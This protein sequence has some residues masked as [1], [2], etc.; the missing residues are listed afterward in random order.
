MNTY[1]GVDPE[2]LTPLERTHFLALDRFVEHESLRATEQLVRQRLGEP[3]GSVAMPPIGSWQVGAADLASLNS[4]PDAQAGADGLALPSSGSS[5]SPA[6]LRGVEPRSAAPSLLGHANSYLPRAEN[7]A[8]PGR[9][10]PSLVKTINTIGREARVHRTPHVDAEDVRPYPGSVPAA[11]SLSRLLSAADIDDSTGVGNVTVVERHLSFSADGAELAAS[12]DRPIT[13]DDLDNAVSSSD[14]PSRARRLGPVRSRR[15]RGRASRGSRGSGSRALRSRSLSRSLSRPS[16]LARAQS[17]HAGQASLSRASVVRSN[18][19]SLRK[20]MAAARKTPT[21]AQSSMRLQPSPALLEQGETV[22]ATSALAMT[23]SSPVCDA[24]H[25]A[26][27]SRLSPLPSGSRMREAHRES[28]LPPLP[29]PLQPLLTPQLAP[30]PTPNPARA[31]SSNDDDDDDSVPAGFFPLSFFDDATFDELNEKLSLPNYAVSGLSK[32]FDVDGSWSWKP[33]LV[34]GYNADKALYQIEWLSNHSLKWVSRLNL[35]FDGE[36]MSLFGARLQ[37]ALVARRE[38]EAMLRYNVRI[39]LMPTDG[40]PELDDAAYASIV[41]RVGRDFPHAATLT[42]R[43]RAVAAAAVTAELVARARAGASDTGA[44]PSAAFEPTVAGTLFTD[45]FEEAVRYHYKRTINQMEF[46]ATLPYRAINPAEPLPAPTPPVAIPQLGTLVLPHHDFAGHFASLASAHFLARPNLAAA[47]RASWSFLASV[48]D[49]PLLLS[50]LLKPKSRKP[51]KAVALASLT[52]FLN[53]QTFYMRNTVRDVRYITIQSLNNALD[54][55]LS[56]HANAAPYDVVEP[57]ALVRLVNLMLRDALAIVLASSIDDYTATFVEYI[58]ELNRMHAAC[59]EALVA[60]AYADADYEYEYDEEESDPDESTHPVASSSASLAPADSAPSLAG[61]ADAAADGASASSGKS[62]KKRTKEEDLSALV[63]SYAENF[64]TGNASPAPDAAL[65]PAST[66]ASRR[67]SAVS[68]KSDV[69]EDAP[70]FAA[71]ASKTLPP[72]PS[73]TTALAPPKVKKR[74]ARTLTR[75]VVAASEPG[76][77]PPAPMFQLFGVPGKYL[78]R[79]TPLFTVTL[80]VSPDSDGLLVYSPSV[81][82]VREV[83]HHLVDE[84]V[85]AIQDLPTVQ[86]DEFRPFEVPPLLAPDHESSP[87]MVQ[88]RAALDKALDWSGAYMRGY[89]S[90]LERFHVLLAQT[91]TEYVASFTAREPKPKPADYAD[92]VRKVESLIV[93]IRSLIDERVVMGMFEVRVVEVKAELERAAHRLRRALLKALRVDTQEYCQALD[94]R[95]AAINVKL[96]TQPETPEEL[97]MLKKFI[98]SLPKEKRKLGKRAAELSARFALLE[99][100]GYEISDAIASAHYHI[101]SWPR[102]LDTTMVETERLMGLVRI[103]MTREIKEKLSNLEA[104][105]IDA[106]IAIK[107]FD[108]ADNLDDAE[109]LGEQA[110]AL[111]TTLRDLVKEHALYNKHERLFEFEPSP[112]PVLSEALAEFKP[113]YT[114]WSNAAAWF[115]KQG[116]WLGQTFVTLSASAMEKF[117]LKTYKTN[118]KVLRQLR[119]QHIA[120]ATAATALKEAI[121]TFRAHMPIIKKLRH[122]GIRRRHWAQLNEKTGLNISPQ[123]DWNLYYFVEQHLENHIEEVTKVADVAINEYNLET[124]LDKMIVGLKRESF[125]VLPYKGSDTFIIGAPD[126]LVTLLDDYTVSVATMLSSPFIGPLEEATRKFSAKLKLVQATIDKWLL[127]QRSWMYLNPIFSSDDINRA[128]PRGSMLYDAVDASWRRTMNKV[129]RSPAVLS[130]C[131][132][133]DVLEVLIECHD[134]LEQI[135]ELL[136]N[137]LDVK[138]SV[139]PRFYFL[140]NDELLDILAKSTDPTRVQPYL[141]KCFE[142]ID[143]LTMV[144]GAKSRTG[145][146]LIDITA[147]NSA[148]GE[149]I[150]FS[151]AVS[152]LRDVEHWLLDVQSAMRTALAAQV[153]DS[154]ADHAAAVREDWV[155]AWPGQIVLAV[156]QLVFTQL[157]TRCLRDRD[158]RGLKILQAKL[159]EQLNRLTELV[160]SPLTRLQQLTLGSLFVMDV[161]NRDTVRELI[162]HKVVVE[163]DFRWQAQMRFYMEDD[164]EIE[165]RMV[166]ATLAY[167]YEYL[168]NTSR[169]VITPL[170]DRCYRTLMSAQHLHLGGAPAGPAGTGKTE[171]CKDLA[172]AVAKQCVVFNCSEALDYLQ[173]GKFFKGLASA[174]AWACFDEFNRIEIEVLSVIASQILAIQR[175]VAAG[176]KQLMFEGTLLDLDPT[177]TVFITMNPGYAGRT[178]LPNNLKALFRPVAMMKADYAFIGE[179]L[180]YSEGFKS[181]PSLSRKMVNCFKLAAEQLSSQDHYDFGMRTIKAVLSTAGGL[182]RASRASLGRAMNDDD[183]ALILYR[184][185]SDCNVPKLVADDIPLFTG[186]LSDLFPTASPPVPDYG[187]L[188]DAILETLAA[189]NLQPAPA[190]IHKITQYYETLQVRHGVMLVGTAGTGK[191]AARS[192]LRD[193]LTATGEPVEDHVINPKSITMGQLYGEVNE[194]TMEWSDGI[195]SHIVRGIV[196]RLAE[197]PPASAPNGAHPLQWIVFDGPVDSLWIE[198]MN[199]VLDDNKLL[200]LPNS[201]RIKIPPRV[202][203]V[204]E[205][206][207]L[208]QASPATVSRCG[209]VY[210]NENTIE[211]DHWAASWRARLVPHVAEAFGSIIDRL[212]TSLVAPALSLV[213]RTELSLKTCT[214]GLMRSLLILLDVLI[215]LV[216]PPESRVASESDDSS[217]SDDDDDADDDDDDFDIDG[218]GS[219]DDAADGGDELDEAALAAASLASADEAKRAFLEPIGTA[220]SDVELQSVFECV[221]AWAVAWSIGTILES[222]DDRAAFD[223]IVREA[224]S[225]KKKAPAPALDPRESE[226]SGSND[227]A[228][229]GP[230]EG[231]ETPAPP[232]VKTGPKLSKL[233][234]P[235]PQEGTIFDYEFKLS[236]SEVG[237]RAWSTKLNGFEL[238][239]AIPLS[240]VFVPTVESVSLG[241]VAEL[242]IR[243]HQRILLAGTSGAGKT[244]GLREVLLRKL[245]S[246]FVPTFVGFSATVHAGDVQALLASKVDRRRKGV[247]GPM[248]GKSL[249]VF[250]DDLNMPTPEKYGARPPIQLLRQV[251]DQG[252]WYD[253]ESLDKQFV[254][255]VDVQLAG[256]LTL[257]SGKAPVSQ[258]LLRHFNVLYSP[259]Y[260]R[261]SL[262]YIFSVILKTH[263]SKFLSDIRSLS[264]SVI[265]ATFDVY[266]AVIEHFKPTPSKPHYVF[267]MRNLFKVFRGMLR[268]SPEKMVHAAEWLLLWRHECTREFGDRLFGADAAVFTGLVDTIGSSAF[269]RPVQAESE[270]L[271][272]ARF[273]HDDGAYSR[274][275]DGQGLVERVEAAKTEYNSMH[276]AQLDVVLFQNALEHVVRLVRAIDQ[277]RG[278][279]LLLGTPGGSGRKSLTR[280]AAALCDYDLFTIELKSKYSRNEWHEDLR[281]VLK[282]AGAEGEPVVFLFDEAQAIDEAFLEDLDNI[283]HNGD[284]PNLFGSDDMEI[285]SRSVTAALQAKGGASATVGL[286]REAVY[287]EFVSR[288]GPTSILSSRLRDFPSLVT[289][290]TLDWYGPWPIEALHAV[291]TATLEHTPFR[292]GE[293]E[294]VPQAE[295]FGLLSSVVEVAVGMHSS[296]VQLAEEYTLSQLYVT[297]SRFVELL[298]FARDS[299]MAAR[300]SLQNEVGRF[301]SG[302]AQLGKVEALVATLQEDLSTKLPVLSKT[303]TEVEALIETLTVNQAEAKKTKAAVE[304]EEVQAQAEQK[305]CEQMVERTEAELSEALP[306]LEAAQR[307]LQELRPSDIVEIRSMQHPP[308][309]MTIAIEAVCILLG[310]RP[311]MVAG[312]RPGS[313]VP[314]YWP[315]ARSLMAD[316]FVK[317][318]LGFEPESITAATVARLEPYITNPKFATAKMAKISVPCAKMT[319]WVTS[320]Y[321]FYFVN[322]RV[323]PLRAEAEGAKVSLDETLARL[324]AARAT[325]REVEERIDELTAEYVAADER[326]SVLEAEVEECKLKIARAEE[327]NDGLGDEKVRWRERVVELSAEFGSQLGDV[328][329]AAGVVVYLGEVGTQARRE[330]VAKWRAL[331]EGK[332]MMV[333]ADWSVVK[334]FGDELQLLGW[335]ILGLPRGGYSAENAVIASSTSKWPLLVDPQGQANSWI[336]RAAQAGPEPVGGTAPAPASPSHGDDVSGSNDEG[337]SDGEPSSA[338]LAGTSGTP[339]ESAGTGGSGASLGSGLGLVVVKPSAPD[340]VRVVEAAIVSGKTLLLED[341]GEELPA[342]LNELVRRAVVVKDGMRVVRLADKMVPYTESFQM[343]MTSRRSGGF[344]PQLATQVTLVNFA[345]TRAGL[346][347]QLLAVVVAKENQAIEAKKTTIIREN[348]ADMAALSALEDK[349]LELLSSASGDIL[350]DDVLIQTL[351]NSKRTSIDIA[352]RLKEAAVT[353][354]DIDAA[355]SQFKPVAL[356]GTELYFTS[357]CLEKLDPMYQ[358]SLRWFLNVYSGTIDAT[359]HVAGQDMNGRLAALNTALSSAFYVNVCRS[360]FEE[361]KLLFSLH[362]AVTLNREQLDDDELNFVQRGAGLVIAA[363]QEKSVDID[364][365]LNDASWV[366]VC[367]LTKLPAFAGLAESINGADADGWRGVY[368]AAVPEAAM[369]PG[370]WSSGLTTLQR[371]CILRCLRPDR[372]RTMLASLVEE[373]LGREFVEPPP[374]SLASAFEDSRVNVPL[375]FILSPGVDPL[376]ELYKFGASR[377]MSSERIVV[378]SLGQGQEARAVEQIEKGIDFGHWVVLQN[379]HLLLSWMPALEKIVAELPDENGR[380]H[381]KFRLWLTSKPSPRFPVSILQIGVKIT[382]E[383]PRGVRANMRRSYVSFSEDEHFASDARRDPVA[384]KL[385]WMLTFFHALVQERRKFGPLGWN[386]AYEFSESDLLASKEQL[387]LLLEANQDVPFYALNY[388]TGEIMYGGRITDDW[389]RRL[390]ATLLGGLFSKKVLSSGWRYT[391]TGEYRA[392]GAGPLS[393][394][395][396]HIDALPEVDSAEVFGLHSNAELSLAVVEGLKLCEGLVSLGSGGSGS[397]PAAAAATDEAGESK[398]DENEADTEESASFEAVVAERVKELLALVPTGLDPRAVRAKYPL[399]HEDSMA[400]VL[401]HD[402]TRYNSLLGVVEGSLTDL[403]AALQGRI[404]MSAALDAV[405][406][407]VFDGLVPGAWGDAGYLSEKALGPWMADLRSRLEFLQR[408]FEDGPPVVYGLGKFFYPQAFL[409]GV[410]QNYARKYSVA[411]DGVVFR[412]HVMDEGA[413]LAEPPADGAYVSGFFIEGARWDSV[414]GVLVEQRDKELISPMPPIWLEPVVASGDGDGDEA[415]EDPSAKNALYDCPV[416][417]TLARYGQVSTAGQS[418]NFVLAVGLPT[419]REPGHWVRR[420]VAMFLELRE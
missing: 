129:S 106:S 322:E 354:K 176:S 399:K 265:S 384:H 291:G 378:I 259:E 81:E 256:A 92:E 272:F 315:V 112:L 158:L 286:T 260:E 420:S 175:G 171:T 143:S 225:R 403:L 39:D 312:P 201:E 313:K 70:T 152:T 102:K 396:D 24:S 78:P 169:L 89:L 408:W 188:D 209:M 44:G 342:V 360:L 2:R 279:A 139:F 414:R 31:E 339:G 227:G 9:A 345:V 204:F 83:L 202:S 73:T 94:E 13:L 183:E 287:Q 224:L 142:N 329:L 370:S 60:A 392:P 87:G 186:I 91:H 382:N 172:K 56:A 297:P 131:D 362:L 247:F 68:A 211:W 295:A 99:S 299:Y 381:S 233:M 283:L 58:D 334:V 383:P 271:L 21:R 367:E 348:A 398:A 179:I 273:A 125:E 191:S 365:W 41:K 268:A 351:K 105:A 17:R 395:L 155:L 147:M 19:T 274:V 165:V 255:L 26:T 363:D 174:G 27:P 215:P 385:T 341:V 120:G 391:S 98:A 153:R 203:F 355:R 288:V 306:E 137:Y 267:N 257:G 278:H 376:K 419:D 192:V 350:E 66:P 184:A 67:P 8:T 97:T 377:G 321:K 124:T 216:S 276:S 47:L 228:G 33:C 117:I 59:A 79:K 168:G 195:L 307:A 210:V 393:E 130:V 80:E 387:Y 46:D 88:A 69:P 6:P 335:Q 108:F 48:T 146:Q 263:L 161:H 15:G 344:P 18:T 162:A 163:S 49:K 45:A 196:E 135:M 37:A 197:P 96:T 361:H 417:K 366:Q 340:L 205:V 14:Q 289:A 5:H 369:W 416:Y 338:D 22:R 296:M 86:I 238:D 11:S 418:N 189:A 235:L 156:N 57:A 119:G 246:R 220:Y 218:D 397:A 294:R 407:R 101:L 132:N 190:F 65:A 212:M 114:L 75:A 252:G 1:E 319:D 258:R 317:K 320:M 347:E 364:E 308:P 282:L 222:T 305:V 310:H 12:A 231:A 314:D 141:R 200:C 28:P 352:K 219:D 148:E 3:A 76:V 226:M 406:Q 332:N 300:Q 104:R 134:L 206:R 62:R 324:E 234:Y 151:S 244:Y 290:C 74:R 240:Q 375:I 388:L 77:P 253:S 346:E 20:I 298:K 349:I 394:Y 337:E 304:S 52:D 327:L 270:P 371:M 303:R 331:V 359:A 251:C 23:L 328:L 180:L 236:V 7:Y 54:A 199:T 32:F 358:F 36:D 242:L 229:A 111:R 262:E 113:I 318:L 330:M 239:A 128:L 123:A 34:V 157:V 185:L 145:R 193:A 140:S 264:S 116:T 372:M 326:K 173:M 178:E 293:G 182:M 249:V 122:P 213:L 410:L 275:R 232:A 374:F 207:D 177:C 221:F 311:K 150:A 136:Q 95:Y 356:R 277:E 208:S 84:T 343:Y 107:S 167:G 85:S 71:T 284:V 133:E 357:A 390:C 254:E 53:D 149:S 93:D 266:A 281:T 154:L 368:E 25:H 373:L 16:S 301:R 245:D 261:E 115:T 316:G 243:S 230:V 40:L 29:P 194:V 237:W 309:G 336:R 4:R 323:K 198:S 166:L 409:T 72:S 63:S 118:S 38:A 415:D 187:N 241:F 380:V 110:A 353:E 401:Y 386:K 61:A 90:R 223:A 159:V 30:T 138:R 55:G 64:V 164:G 280:L 412:A 405:A 42:D 325:L 126:D 109:T 248:P 217:G 302:L 82:H 292:V 181:A 400:T 285:I 170:T 10:S 379:C 127:V 121:E 404:V 144:D 269:S 214:A 413:V 51:S 250:V 43:Q 402:C 389:D 50:F 35:V 100:F 411:I 103:N 160:C 333:S